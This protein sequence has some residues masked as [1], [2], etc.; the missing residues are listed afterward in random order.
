MERY[1]LGLHQHADQEVWHVVGD[2]SPSVAV[3][4]VQGFLA[5]RLGPLSA[6]LAWDYLQNP[7]H[8]QKACPECQAW[9]DARRPAVDRLGELT[10]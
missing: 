6:A 3:C 7:R 10:S 8:G 9:V 5:I 4:G 2:S 1:E